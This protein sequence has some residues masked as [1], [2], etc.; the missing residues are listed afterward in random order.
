MVQPTAWWELLYLTPGNINLPLPLGQQE[1]P[2]LNVVSLHNVTKH[3]ISHMRGCPAQDPGHRSDRLLQIK[4]QPPRG[5]LTI[6]THQNA[7]AIQ[8]ALILRSIS[9]TGLGTPQTLQCRVLAHRI[10]ESTARHTEVICAS[11]W[12]TLNRLFY[13]AAL[14]YTDHWD[15]FKWRTSRKSRQAITSI[16]FTS[17]GTHYIMRDIFQDYIA[18]EETFRL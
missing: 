16:L 11:F 14:L 10:R 2:N 4:G 6:N 9:S 5:Y 7:K 18:T 1:E 3:H 13:P 17:G 12:Q 8:I 15:V